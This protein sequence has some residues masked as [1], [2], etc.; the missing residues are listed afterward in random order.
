[1]R[2]DSATSPPVAK[3]VLRTA[4]TAFEAMMLKQLLQSALP[5]PDGI[6]GD[7]Q[8]IAL[9]VFARDLATAQPFGLARLMESNQPETGK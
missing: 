1:M 6:A 4:A 3:A 2:I 9:D 8:S 7:W 5:A